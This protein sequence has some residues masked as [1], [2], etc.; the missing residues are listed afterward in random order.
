[1]RWL[2]MKE[3]ASAGR[4]ASSRDAATSRARMLDPGL[5]S[6]DDMDLDRSGEFQTVDL[7]QLVEYKDGTICR[8]RRSQSRDACKNEM[9]KQKCAI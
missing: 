3:Q 5:R 1:M 8:Q 9:G 7:F 6:R 4:R 2:V